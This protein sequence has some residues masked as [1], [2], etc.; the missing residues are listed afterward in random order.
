MEYRWLYHFK[1]A[2]L[3]ASFAFGLLSVANIVPAAYSSACSGILAACWIFE[4]LRKR[5][6]FSIVASVAF[7]FIAANPWS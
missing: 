1:L 3:I 7:A 2:L 4:A 5:N 6:P